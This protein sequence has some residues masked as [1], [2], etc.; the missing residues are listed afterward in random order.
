MYILRRSKKSVLST[1]VNNSSCTM[2]T[3]ARLQIL[4]QRVYYPL[5]IKGLYFSFKRYILHMINLPQGCDI[6]LVRKLYFRTKI[7]KLI[8][9]N[10]SNLLKW[11]SRGLC[12]FCNHISHDKT[13]IIG[14]KTDDI[15]TY[16]ARWLVQ[17][18]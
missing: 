8:H 11:R 6:D 18:N 4:S 10:P 3:L 9:R 17:P 13:V 2:C 15:H 1:L 7:R 12:I 5:D 14:N 16:T